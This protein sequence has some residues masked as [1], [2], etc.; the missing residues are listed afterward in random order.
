MEELIT[1]KDILAGFVLMG[2]FYIYVWM[3][4]LVVPESW[5]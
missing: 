3:I 5:L 4:Y 1:I 2:F